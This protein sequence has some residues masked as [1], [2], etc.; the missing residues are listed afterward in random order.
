MLA[1]GSSAECPP[2][3]R[4]E[5]PAAHKPAPLL[6]LILYVVAALG[7]TLGALCVAM[8]GEMLLSW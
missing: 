3:E 2:K 1:P 4:M 5:D 6:D 7:I 8:C